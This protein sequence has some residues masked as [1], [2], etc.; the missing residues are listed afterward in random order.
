[1]DTSGAMEKT[2]NDI[3]NKMKVISTKSTKQSNLENWGIGNA[4]AT[5]KS[6]NTLVG[7]KRNRMDNDRSK[8]TREDVSEFNVSGIR[9]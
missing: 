4:S 3:V 6:N 7:Q 8:V 5:S 2:K 9:K 1:M